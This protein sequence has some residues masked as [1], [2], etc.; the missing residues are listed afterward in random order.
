LKL[1][2]TAKAAALWTTP[3]RMI[4]SRQRTTTDVAI[5]VGLEALQRQG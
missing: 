4:D 2:P 1:S 5:G 3:M